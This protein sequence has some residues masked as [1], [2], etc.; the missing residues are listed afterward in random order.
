MTTAQETEVKNENT[1]VQLCEDTVEVLPITKWTSSAIHALRSGDIEIWAE[2]S[3]TP[4]SYQIWIE[5]DPTLDE[6][7]QFMDE[8]S[9]ASGAR[10][11]VS[12]QRR[13]R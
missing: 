3:L 2:K 13:Q 12:R 11:K 7:E 10:L 5:L 8:W 6:I 9:K 1:V 4:D